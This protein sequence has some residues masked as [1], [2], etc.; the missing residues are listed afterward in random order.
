[1]ER[2]LI[3]I[4]LFFMNKTHSSW[5]LPTVIKMTSYEE[6]VSELER[7]KAEAGESEN[8][9]PAKVG[10][11]KFYIKGTDEYV[12]MNISSKQSTKAKDKM[13]WKIKYRMNDLGINKRELKRVIANRM[14]NIRNARLKAE[15]KP[16]GTKVVFT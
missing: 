2:V 11:R 14:K 3:T 5:T 16:E 8:G 9:G 7:F 12:T 10:L 13:D 1:M 6:L 15:L 4:H